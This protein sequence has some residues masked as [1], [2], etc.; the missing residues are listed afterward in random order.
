MDI[1]TKPSSRPVADT[2]SKLTGMINAKG[3]KLFA[4][5]DQS[6]EARQVGLTLRETALVIFGSPWQARR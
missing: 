2:V 1:V 5:I 3:M 4:A 6:A